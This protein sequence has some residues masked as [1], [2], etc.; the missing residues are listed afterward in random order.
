MPHRDILFAE[1]CKD[2]VKIVTATKTYLHHE[3]MKGMTELLGGQF[4]RAHRSFIVA[5]ARIKLLQAEQLVLTTGDELPIG[6]S[7]KADLLAFFKK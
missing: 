4:V 5:A 7:Y 2:Y 6:N 3:T 1:G